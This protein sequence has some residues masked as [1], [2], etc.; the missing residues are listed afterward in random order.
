LNLFII[1]AFAANG[2]VTGG[3]TGGVTL[4]NP[5]G[6]GDIP[7]LLGKVADFFY[8]IG[9]PL[10]TIMVLVGAFQILTAAGEPEKFKTGQKTVIYAAIG[11][12][13]ILISKGITLIIKELFGVS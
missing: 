11:F 1:K 3:T 4:P 12:G 6:S 13:I 7:T 9:I 2:S 5:L 10:L 8:T